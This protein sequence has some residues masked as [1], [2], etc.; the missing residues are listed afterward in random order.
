MKVGTGE[1]ADYFND[2]KL[3]KMNFG[4][5][6]SVI[7]FDQTH[8]D[9][10][11]VATADSGPNIDLSHYKI[12]FYRLTFKDLLHIHSLKNSNLTYIFFAILVLGGTSAIGCFVG[13]KKCFG[14]KIIEVIRYSQKHPSKTVD[15]DDEAGDLFKRI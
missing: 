2:T 1:N 6:K 7:F 5:S 9:F 12:G 4:F 13:L 11:F 15:S 8:F 14:K 3:T 10:A